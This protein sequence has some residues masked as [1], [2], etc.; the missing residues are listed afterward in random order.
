MSNAEVTLDDLKRFND[1]FT[2]LMTQGRAFNKIILGC[3]KMDQIGQEGAKGLITGTLMLTAA[4]TALGALIIHFKESSKDSIDTFN[5]FNKTTLT[6]KD[7]I[8]HE[9]LQGKK[10]HGYRYD[11]FIELSRAL[12]R[13]SSFIE[14]N[15]KDL[16]VKEVIWN[17]NLFPNVRVAI[18]G[19]DLHAPG[20]DA[21]LNPGWETGTVAELGWDFDKILGVVNN[22]KAVLASSIKLSHVGETVRIVTEFL[23]DEERSVTRLDTDDERHKKEVHLVVA[24]KNFY[25]F[26][27]AIQIYIYF[28]SHMV[29][30][31]FS[32]CRAAQ[33]SLPI[34]ERLLGK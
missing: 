33:K 4:V 32:L 18:I 13:I 7:L 22:M 3:E 23:H 16:T 26:R 34:K 12:V 11:R 29:A 5:K 31:F 19:N 6:K 17:Q 2:A 30:E 9:K 25:N 20:G 1:Q 15:V 8:N 24:R 28:A 21:A 14:A 10:I 27:Y